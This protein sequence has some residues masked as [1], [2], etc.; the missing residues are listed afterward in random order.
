MRAR[1]RAH[2]G[3]RRCRE[4]TETGT[5]RDAGTRGIR[6]TIM[7]KYD[8]N[9]HNSSN[10][11]NGN[12]MNNNKNNSNNDNG[13][14]RRDERS[15]TI[16]Y[17]AARDRAIRYDVMRMTERGTGLC[18]KTPLFCKPLPCSPTAETAIQ[19]LIWCSG[20]LYFHEFSSP[21]E[22]FFTGHRYDPRNPE[23]RARVAPQRCPRSWFRLLK[24]FNFL[25]R[26]FIHLFSTLCGPVVL[27]QW[28]PWI[29][30]YKL[31]TAVRISTTNKRCPRSWRSA[32]ITSVKRATSVPAD[33]PACGLDFARFPSELCMFTE[34]ARLVPPGKVVP[35]TKI[36]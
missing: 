12:D 21:G 29:R 7:R 28:R 9:N 14:M 5:R 20:S 35:K 30:A 16:G 26:F 31:S 27:F 19:R 32:A 22:S 17:R 1:G 8:I 23:R 33:G 6:I 36:T 13:R 24:P 25:P 18:G 3:A 11:D 34:V 15:D 2:G 10:S 4:A